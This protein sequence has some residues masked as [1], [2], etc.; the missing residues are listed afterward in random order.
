[1]AG[2]LGLLSGPLL[3]LVLRHLESRM[4]SKVAEKRI[5]ADL[6]AEEIRSEIAARGEARKLAAVES[7]HLLSAARIGRLLFVLPLGLWWS[8]VIADSIFSFAWN[9][10]A[11]PPPLDDWAGAILV[12]LFLVDGFSAA[13]RRLRR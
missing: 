1:M 10:A 3:G 12:S 2:L 11:L 8:A 9:V 4:E 6:A 5:A 7:E 13:A